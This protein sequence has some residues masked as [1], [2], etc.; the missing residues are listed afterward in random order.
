MNSGERE[1]FQRD[2]LDL[3]FSVQLR[4]H[5][6]MK[7]KKKNTCTNLEIPWTSLTPQYYNIHY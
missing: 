6:I 2:K 5:T 1:Q 4:S 7:K 3:Q